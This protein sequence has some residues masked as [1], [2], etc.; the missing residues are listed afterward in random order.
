M[1]QRYTLSTI[2]GSAFK[3]ARMHSE[4]IDP[5]ICPVNGPYVSNLSVSAYDSSPSARDVF[6]MFSMR[7]TAPI[8]GSLH[9]GPWSKSNKTL[10]K[11][12]CDNVEPSDHRVIKIGQRN[13]LLIT[14]SFSNAFFN[15]FF[16]E[17][18]ILNFSLFCLLKRVLLLKSD[19]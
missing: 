11:L 6:S 18:L 3:N 5:M 10:I 4:M 1:E 7:N 12:T 17:P 15:F 13:S 16:F 9:R 8:I 2:L 19:F 14:Y